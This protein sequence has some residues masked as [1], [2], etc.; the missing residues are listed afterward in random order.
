[1]FR[2]SSPAILQP[3]N[4]AIE[5]LVLSEHSGN[6]DPLRPGSLAPSAT[7]CHL[8]KNYL[9]SWRVGVEGGSEGQQRPIDVLEDQPERDCVTV[10]HGEPQPGHP[11]TLERHVQAKI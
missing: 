6:A 11:I 10:T 7:L 9:S 5:H 1:M 3:C 2:E 4:L 8:K